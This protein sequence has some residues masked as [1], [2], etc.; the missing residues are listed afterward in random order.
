MTKKNDKEKINK[1]AFV[2]FSG[3]EKFLTN[4]DKS[5]LPAPNFSSFF[6]INNSLL[7]KK[8]SPSGL[9]C[10]VFFIL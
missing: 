3:L 6:I 5:L 1:W 8:N 7:I 2:M 9:G 4:V 10:V